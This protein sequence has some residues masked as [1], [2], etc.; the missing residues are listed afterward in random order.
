MAISE[1][2][3]NFG[4]RWLV[5]KPSRGIRTGKYRSRWESRVALQL[6]RVAHEFEPRD[7]TI[8]YK[9]EHTYLPDFILKNGIIIEAKGVFS[10]RDRAKHIAIKAQHPEIDIRI[11]FQNSE[12][13][14][15]KKS[16]TT[17]GVWC[18]KHNIQWCH[19]LI[20][21]SWLQPQK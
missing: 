13:K 8:P 7:K 1:A 15:S 21:D 12:V 20:P 16:R 10:P 17:Y 3:R 18:T 6:R 19:R 11:V 2:Q 4:N 14:I 5:S 9:L